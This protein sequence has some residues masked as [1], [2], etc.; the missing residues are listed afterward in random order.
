MSTMRP[1]VAPEAVS[2]PSTRIQSRRSRE[3]PSSS[4]CTQWL[5]EFSATWHPAGVEP[6]RMRPDTVHF[7]KHTDAPFQVGT[8]I[9]LLA[10]RRDHEGPAVVQYRDFWGAQK[11]EALLD[12]ATDDPHVHTTLAP[13]KENRCLGGGGRCRSPAQSTRLGNPGQQE[14]AKENIDLRS[15]NDS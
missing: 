13:A 6:S 1:S 10:R 14:R 11:R 9:S 12:A 5:A 2:R 15:T 3:P 7:V 8:A 4:G